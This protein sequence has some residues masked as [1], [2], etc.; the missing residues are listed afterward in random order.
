[1]DAESPAQRQVEQ[2]RLVLLL[3]EDDVLTRCTAAAYLREAGYRV[4]EAANAAEAI[5]VLSSSSHVDVV[6]SDVYMPG[7]LNGYGLERWI[8]RYHPAVPVL[9]TSGAPWA[10][11]I[12]ADSNCHFVAKPY[13]LTEVE[14]LIKTML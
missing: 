8:S 6:F 10:G 4:I 2:N 5:S 3:V 12:A 7:E 11:S 13:H 14:W 1:L 9:L